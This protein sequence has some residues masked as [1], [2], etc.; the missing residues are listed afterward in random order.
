MITSFLN[1]MNGDW[2]RRPA[3]RIEALALAVAGIMLGSVFCFVRS[4]LAVCV[5]ATMVALVTALGAIA[6]SYFSNYWFPWLV[7]AGG[8]VPCALA[9]ALA[10]RRTRAAV[11][12]LERV[13]FPLPFPGA[14]A[15]SRF[16]HQLPDIPG[17][18]LLNPPFGEGA[19]GRVWLARNAAGEW[20]A[21]KVV[22]LA[23]FDQNP[24][25][26]EREFNGIRRY[27]PIS[28]KHPGLLR[29][30]FVSNKQEDGYFYYVMELGDPLVP[31]WEKE[32]STYRPRDLIS[33]R[34][35]S[36]E[37][38]LP[39][40]ECVRLGLALTDALDFLHQQGLTHRDIKPQNIIF[41]N[42]HPKLADMGLIA[43]IRPP[44]QE[45][46]NVGTPGYMP[47]LPELPGTP[48]ADIFALGM[49]LYVLSTG[50]S[51]A[52]FP[53]LST[54][55]VNNTGM[56]D[57]FP[58]NAVILKACNPDCAQRYASAAEMRRALIEVQEKLETKAADG[59]STQAW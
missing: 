33:E 1:L 52:F 28:D 44:D 23:N 11:T 13:G 57:F 19:Y 36:R 58:L 40:R 30:D 3:W 29:V 9:W 50:R 5:A 51:P 39:V 27:K 45:R 56:A 14:A 12:A 10:T 46:T 16:I 43:E 59:S 41:V 7:I 21:L 54:T 42:G 20:Q 49:V 26:Y 15:P 37:Q 2:L 53:E 8:Q 18:K 55:L 4:P 25:P 17:Y 6:W 38:K 35:R 22:Y 48:Q 31:G 47:P 32:P 34:K 24:D